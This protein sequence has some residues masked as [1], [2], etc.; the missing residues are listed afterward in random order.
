MKSSTAWRLTFGISAVFWLL[1]VVAVMS[2]TG[3][4][5][6]ADLYY[7]CQSGDVAACKEKFNRDAA[8]AGMNY[9]LQQQKQDEANKPGAPKITHCDRSATGFNCTTF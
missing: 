9:A 7:R 2:L 8:L 5:S 3:C 1:V 6:Y 4:A